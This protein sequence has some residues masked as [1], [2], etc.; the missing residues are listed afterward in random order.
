MADIQDD[1]DQF[2]KFAGESLRM[3]LGVESRLEFFISNYF[4]KPQ[5][6]KTF[7]FEDILIMPMNFEQKINIF[8]KI[9]AREK[10]GEKEISKIIRHIRYVQKVRNK[11][12]HW[13]TESTSKGI[14]QLRKRKSRTTINDT[15][16]LNGTQMK[17]LEHER[18]NAI[19]GIT[20]F[21]LKYQKEGTIDDKDDELW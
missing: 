9:C 5:H 13:Q 18:L 1:I 19:K 16:K 11:V 4:I 3:A 7:F 20:N 14:T 12:A 2:S 10:Y 15:L 6:D 8:K 21:Y 17:K